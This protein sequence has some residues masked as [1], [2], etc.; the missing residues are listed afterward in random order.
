M[1]IHYTEF[2]LNELN[3]MLIWYMCAAKMKH[4]KFSEPKMRSGV[5]IQ[6]VSNFSLL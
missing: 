6:I 5:S 3:C 2:M 4:L 1:F